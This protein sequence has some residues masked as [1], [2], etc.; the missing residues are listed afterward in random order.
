M[1]FLASPSASWII[2]C[3]QES[4]KTTSPLLRRPIHGLLFPTSFSR[5]ALLLY[6]WSRRLPPITFLCAGFFPKVCLDKVP[7]FFLSFQLSSSNER[8]LLLRATL[9]SIDFRRSYPSFSRSAPPFLLCSELP[10][11][12]FLSS[13]LARI[14][15]SH[16]RHIAI[17]PSPR[18]F[19]LLHC[20][21][22][23]SRRN[24]WG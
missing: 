21:A 14:H 4:S 13:H 6:V 24:P 1:G 16:I 5:P 10:Q 18:F 7:L 2:F 15:G 9:P 20:L 22:D 19:G 23:G 17:F 8:D 3:L 12:F 11:L